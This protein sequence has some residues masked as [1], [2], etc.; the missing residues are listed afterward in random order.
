MVLRVAL[1]DDIRGSL[2]YVHL[3]NDVTNGVLVDNNILFRCER[4][5][6]GPY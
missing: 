2:N 4:K 6:K 5:G 1:S 3:T